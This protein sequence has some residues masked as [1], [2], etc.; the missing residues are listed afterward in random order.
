VDDVKGVSR[1][2]TL[3]DYQGLGCALIL[4]DMLGARSRRWGIGCAPIRRTPRW[5]VRSI[6]RRAGC[7]RRKPGVFSPSLGETSGLKKANRTKD[8][9]HA[10][11]KWN[12][13]SRPC[14]VFEFCGDMMKP[15][16]AAAL[17]EGQQKAAHDR[18]ARRAD[19]PPRR[20]CGSRGRAS[21]RQETVRSDRAH[22][23]IGGRE[24]AAHVAGLRVGEFGGL[25]L[26]KAR[27]STRH[28]Q[29]RPRAGAQGRDCGH[30]AGASN[31]P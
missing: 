4:V 28:K 1:L 8:G 6:G 13:G 27:R 9:D 29:K 7:W 21:V 20:L 11:K 16:E 31:K 5:C 2:V 18:M 14:A 15:H 12:M 25:D 19:T 26:A 24:Y 10:G 23:M 17:I 30:W 22:A 3:P